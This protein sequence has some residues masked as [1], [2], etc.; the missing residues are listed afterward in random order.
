MKNDEHIKSQLEKELE[1]VKTR[2][3]ILDMI[4][5]RLIDMRDLA[6]HVADHNLS[7]DE[8]QKIN[9]QFNFLQEQ[10]RML[11]AED[12]VKDFC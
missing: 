2:K 1:S 11:C 8:M 6:Q 3:Q 12:V 4:E 9:Q 10:V 5:E 7:Q